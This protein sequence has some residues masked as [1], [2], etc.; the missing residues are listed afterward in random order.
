M[1]SWAVTVDRRSLLDWCRVPWEQLESHPDLRIPLR[2]VPSSV[3]MGQLMA[4]ELF[5]LITAN[6]SE[7]RSTRVILPCGPMSWCDP[8]A[9][10]VNSS[11]HALHRVI[12]FHMDECL[13]WQGQLLPTG[14]PYNFRSI[15]EREFYGR[16][17]ASLRVPDDQRMWLSPMTMAAVAEE[18]GRAP[19]DLVIGGWGQDGHVAYNQAPRGPYR[20]ISLEDL[21]ASTVRI[22]QN[23]MD[24]VLALAHRT[25]GAAYQFVP[26]MSVTLGMREILGAAQIRLFSDT[27][28]WKKTALRVALFSSPDPEYPVTLM[29]EHPDAV[30]TA[31]IDTADHPLSHHPEWE[32]L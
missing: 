4:T 3:A 30:L 7:G 9:N 20:P 24:T 16:V 12:V 27:G 21:A 26:A 28:A 18:I 32:V 6:D 17:E 1:E 2:I 10:L 22:Q 31:T 23:S 13:D 25:F 19:I 14:H 29:Q 5:N 11:G 15:M 8:F